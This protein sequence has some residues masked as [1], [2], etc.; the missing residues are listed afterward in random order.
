MIYLMKKI[1]FFMDSMIK[2]IQVVNTNYSVMVKQD[3]I[4]LMIL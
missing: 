3:G 2:Q 1:I 4:L